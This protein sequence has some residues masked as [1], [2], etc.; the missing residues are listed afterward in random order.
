MRIAIIGAGIGG[1]ATAARLATR[2]HEVDV[3]EANDYPGGKLS[4]FTLDAYRFDAGPSLFTMPMYV[5]ELFENS[6]EDPRA[7]FS[8]L[9]APLVCRYHWDDGTR[10]SAWSD[11]A[12]FDREAARQLGV[13]E[14]TVLRFLEK[15]KFKYELS[16]RIFLEKSLHRFKTWWSKKV[17]KALLYLPALDLNRSMHAANERGLKHPKLVQLFDRFATYNG[18]NPY[19]APGMLT[20]IPHFEHGFGAYYPKGGMYAITKSV[21]ALA[22]RKG[23][24]FHFSTPV[25]RILVNDGA[26]VGIQVKGETRLYDQVVSNMDIYPTYKHLLPDQPHPERTLAQERSTSALIFYWGIRA[27]FPELDLHN[28]FFSKNYQAEFE[29]H[30][31]GEVCSDPTVY[32]NITTKYDPQDAPPG[33]ETW[34]VMVNVPANSTG[35]D[36]DALTQRIRRQ[37][38]DKLSHNLGRPIEPLIACEATLDPRTIESKTASWQGALYG[39]ASNNMFSAFLRHPNFSSQ[40][41]NL[42]F[43]GGSVHPGGGIPLCLLS[44]KI[45]DSLIAESV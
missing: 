7:H 33:C 39:T 45:T 31:W 27:T 13:P 38:L 25:E 35:Q 44:A 4:E 15:S 28:I 14:G 43:V 42:Y 41:K 19:R 22:E 3:F 20:I 17:A 40:I 12:E 37:V 29:A 1:L 24:R 6:G 5:D 34:F 36:W 32:I 10:L 11:P 18:S 26:A 9:R 16:G 30:S 23:A 21:Y 8:Y 2:G